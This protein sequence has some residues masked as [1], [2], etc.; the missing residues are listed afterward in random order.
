[1]STEDQN[2]NF[3]SLFILAEED[4]T[5]S[6]AQQCHATSRM[7]SLHLAGP[8]QGGRGSLTPAG[9]SR[10]G[11]GHGSRGSPARKPTKTTLCPSNPAILGS[12]A[13]R[14]HSMRD[15]TSHMKEKYQSKYQQRRVSI[16][17]PTTSK[18]TTPKASG[19]R[20]NSLIPTDLEVTRQFVATNKKVINRGDSFKRKERPGV[21]RANVEI[22]INGTNDI[23]ESE[24][25][26]KHPKKV[27]RIAFL[28]SGEVGKTSIIDQFMS[29][30]HADV[31]EDIQEEKVVETEKVTGR[32]LTVDVNNILAQLSLVETSAD[33]NISEVVEE[34][35]PDCYVLVY[36]VDDVES[37]ECMRDSLCWLSDNN[38]LSGKSAILVGNKADLART[39]VVDTGDGCDLAVQ[40]G[41]KF[42]ETSPGMGHHIDE[43]LV[44][45]V[46]QL[47]LHE[48]RSPNQPQQGIKQTLKG[49][50]SIFTGKEDEK[51]KSCRNL[52]I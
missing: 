4:P 10:A 50:L 13:A 29:S 35:N 11:S 16:K 44:G 39:R 23:N 24:I 28:G 49:F 30:E 41:V 27:Y 46:M 7:A 37:F 34:H 22:S 45:I 51:R 1:M 52:N 8:K 48:H 18:E 33:I 31:Y 42:T 38:C 25:V 14:S 9:G 32:I 2:S 17:T 36:A 12:A 43:L 40:A 19:S 6:A 20:N 15:Q 26:D 47:R 3:D 5:L 21:H